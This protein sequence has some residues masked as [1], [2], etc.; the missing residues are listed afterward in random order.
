MDELRKVEIVKDDGRSGLVHVCDKDG[1][2]F[3]VRRAKLHFVGDSW[4]ITSERQAQLARGV[5]ARRAAREVKRQAQLKLAAQAEAP[6]AKTQ[7][8]EVAA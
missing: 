1:N 5:I 6:E 2:D 3:H 7:T 4:V 8:E